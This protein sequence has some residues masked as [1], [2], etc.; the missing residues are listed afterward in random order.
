ML[1]SSDSSGD[2]W[3]IVRASYDTRPVIERSSYDFNASAD[4]RPIFERSSDNYRPIIV[5]CPPMAHRLPVVNFQ[6]CK[7][8][9]AGHRPK[10]DRGQWQ[11]RKFS[12]HPAI[13]PF[14]SPMLRCRRNPSMSRHRTATGVNVTE[15]LTRT[16]RMDRLNFCGLFRD[17][18]VVPRDTPIL[19][20]SSLTNNMNIVN[21]NCNHASYL[22]L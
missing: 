15:V 4:D 8:M 9:S 11:T 16:C 5:R 6:F 10:I 1:S 12:D 22:E 17:T 20:A 19:Q 21:V 3:L 7:H 18:F 2:K 14:F 13:F